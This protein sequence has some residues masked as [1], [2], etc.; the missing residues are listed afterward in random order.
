MVITRLE[1]IFQCDEPKDGNLA[2]PQFLDNFCKQEGFI[3]WFD[4]SA[5]H[6]INVTEAGT[7]LVKHVCIIFSKI[8]AR[9]HNPRTVC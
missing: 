8:T 7:F 5:K 2:N 1:N 3:G 9:K 4:T 6:N